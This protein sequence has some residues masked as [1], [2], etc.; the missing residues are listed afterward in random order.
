M[1]NKLFTTNKIPQALIVRQAP[2]SNFND[3]LKDI[4]KGIICDKHGCGECVWCK[5]IEANQYFDLFVFEGKQMKKQEVINLIARCNR[6][7]IEAC[8]IKVYVIKNIEYAS[9]SILNSL[10]KFV[11]EPPKGVYAIFTTR[12]YNAV[13]PTIRSR[14]FNVYLPKDLQAVDSYLNTKELSLMDKELITKCFYDLESMQNS[15]DNFVEF[16][17][18]IKKLSSPESLHYANEGLNKF[19]KMEYPEINLFLEICKNAFPKIANKVIDLQDNLYLN[20][21]KILIYNQIY[22]LL[23]GVNK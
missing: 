1:K 12:N 10:L 20:S 13:L 5:K 15:Y 8:D 9:K 2:L 6:A 22:Q 4:L 14:C 7:G 16:Y 19:R 17:E 18:L 3:C 23:S 11:E 21:P